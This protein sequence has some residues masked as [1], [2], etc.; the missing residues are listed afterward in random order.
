LIVVQLPPIPR[1][2]IAWSHADVLEWLE[3]NNIPRKAFAK[4]KLTGRDLLTLSSVDVYNLVGETALI[5]RFCE[6][7][8]LQWNQVRDLFEVF[9]SFDGIDSSL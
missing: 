5:S 6:C 8:R 2:I 7:L 4:Q 9:F 3:Y 1:R